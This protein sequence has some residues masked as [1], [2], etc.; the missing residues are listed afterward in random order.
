MTTGATTTSTALAPRIASALLEINATEPAPVSRIVLRTVLVLFAALS[1]WAAVAQ[2]DM[3]AVAEGE[4]VPQTA[5]KIVQ[6]A[7]AGIVREILVQDGD[8]VKTGQVLARLDP[9]VAAAD[10][11][12]ARA[13]LAAKQLELRRI[14]AQLKGGSLSRTA[15]DDPELYVQ[16]QADAAARTRAQQD[17]RRIEEATLARMESELASARETLSKLERTLPSYQQAAEAYARLGEQKL[18]GSL[19][20]A[21]KQR[22]YVE[23]QQDLKSQTAYVSSLESS[24]RSQR[25]KVEQVSSGYDSQLK[26]ERV[27]L[28][29]DVARLEEE[30]TKQG[31]RE[32]LLELKAPQA[33][34][35]KDLATTTLG[36]VV[37]PGTVLLSLV[38]AGEPLV[39]EVYVRNEDIGFV[40]EGQAARIKLA[41]Y[42]FT[43]YG[44][45]EGRV[46]TLSADAMRL[47][48]LSAPQKGADYASMSP[49][50]AR[51][52]LSDQRLRWEATT[53]PMVAGMQVQ[54]EV[55]QGKRTIIEYLL[56]PVLRVASEAGSER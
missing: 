18:V 40:R 29:A 35:V 19:A 2:L 52:R 38:P 8:L 3:V 6:P 42:P 45:L 13:Q 46:V 26:A 55:S 24:L 49:F 51:I 33:G 43:K 30:A 21:E 4:L 37:Q 28:M 27:Q 47:S 20:A 41:A 53:L 44:M 5:V 17:V 50:K 48:D 11:R 32:G 12:S 9:T 16:V 36:A 23:K 22:E 1:V 7:E 54:A 15:T 39:A 56:S 25:A 34:V 10:N 14:D 31:F